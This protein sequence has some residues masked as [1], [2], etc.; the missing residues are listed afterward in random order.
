MERSQLALYI[1]DGRQT[2]DANIVP[3]RQWVDV[4]HKKLGVD[5]G[6]IVLVQN[7]IRAPVE[8]RQERTPR[9]NG[10]TGLLLLAKS[11][12][13]PTRNRLSITGRRAGDDDATLGDAGVLVFLKPGRDAVVRA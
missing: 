3:G 10:A 7:S 1:A 4:L 11:R 2:A 12:A 5:E 6:K 9:T 13:T 8:W